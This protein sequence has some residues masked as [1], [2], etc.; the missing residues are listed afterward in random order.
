MTA[1]LG[2]QDGEL[3]ECAV[4][5]DVAGEFRGS[6]FL[7]SPSTVVTAAHVVVDGNGPASE[8]RIHHST[9]SYSVAARDIRAE[10]RANDG[11]LFHPFP[12]LAVLPVP[13]L[14]GRSVARLAASDAAWHT[15]LTALGYSLNTPTPGVQPD[16]LALRVAGRSGDFVK[17]LGDGVREGLSG[18][19]LLGTDG[20]VYGV[21]KGSR[22][23]R[24]DSGGWFVPVSVLAAFLGNDV[25][26]APAKTG[27][28]SPPTDKEIVDALMAFPVMTR[29][30][31]RYDLLDRM[32][33]HLGL[34]HS[35]EVEERADRRD[36]L[37][38]L[39]RR[40]RHYRDGRAAFRSL[41]TAME[42]LVPYDG[43]LD[44]LRVVVGRAI[45]GWEGEVEQ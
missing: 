38:R 8:V 43:A 9:G 3:R 19:M 41:Y 32:G 5:I 28:I 39:V 29:L 15:E 27:A 12:D 2:P 26:P 11:G 34:P 31:G 37:H 24:D 22:S 42:E 7:V 4:W 33:D 35:F 45:G 13:P 21:V 20:L 1:Q 25:Q 30:D 14:D 44:R 23:Y 18:S 40:C 17:V 6:G 16:T 10:P 36:H